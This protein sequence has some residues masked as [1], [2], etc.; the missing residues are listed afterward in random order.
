M[1][2][3]LIDL[4]TIADGRGTL[5]AIEGAQD[6]PF[7]IRRVFYM[8]HVS[9]N[10]GGHAHIDTDQVLI[11]AHG[12]LRVRLTCGRESR[13]YLMDD[14]TKGL[15]IPRLYFTEMEGFTPET[16]CL[17]LSSTHY[18]MGRSLRSKEAYLAYI[19]E[20]GMLTQDG[21]PQDEQPRDDTEV[22]EDRSL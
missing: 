16:V 9:S 14:C 13:E 1:D 21:F 2:S 6:I 8:H 22:P 17:V 3:Y 20:H 15:F 12:S 5:T 19:Q 7:E 18:D 10:R 4:K 11:P